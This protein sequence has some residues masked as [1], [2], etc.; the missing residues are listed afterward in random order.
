MGRVAE[1]SQVLFAATKKKKRRRRGIGNGGEGRER[2]QRSW[3][4]RGKGEK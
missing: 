1:T 3:F 4:G 2:T